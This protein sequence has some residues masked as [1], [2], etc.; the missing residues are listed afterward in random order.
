MNAIRLLPL[1]VIA[2]AL[3]AGC[4]TVPSTNANLDAARS[5][6]RS[7]RDQSP[8]P[9]LAAVEMKQAADALT[10][11]NDAWTRR[12]DTAV[13][14]HLAYVA[15]QRVALAQATTQQKVAERA[16][17]QAESG[18]DKLRLAARTN[19]ADAAAARADTSQRAAAESQRQSAEA[20]RQAEAARRQSTLSQ[21]EVLEAQARNAELETQLKDLNAKKTE[22]GLVVTLGDVLFDTDRSQLKPGGTRN[23]EKLVGFLNRY[24][25]RKAVVEGHTDNTGSAGHNQTLS[26]ERADAVRSAIVGMGITADRVAAQGF[27]E[28][29]PVAGNDSAGGRQLNRRVEIILSDETGVIPAR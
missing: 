27:G 25:Q 28:T 24:P 15:R 20:M 11:A 4:N 16:V 19:E 5:E 23:V 2:A 7:A 12:E 9:E 22:R 6:F 1:T 8:A 3:L 14:D 17:T 10:Q 29:V 18:R 21:Q 13:V 26:G